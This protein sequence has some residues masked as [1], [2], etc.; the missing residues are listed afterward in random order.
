MSIALLDIQILEQMA[1]QVRNGLSAKES[2]IK[3]SEAIGLDF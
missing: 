3:T 2:F 1:P